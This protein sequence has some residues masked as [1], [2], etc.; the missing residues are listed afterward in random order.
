MTTT[1]MEPLLYDVKTAAR[2]LSI[3]E[4]S[5]R[6]LASAGKLPSTRI[7]DRLLFSPK[8]LAQFAGMS[9]AKTS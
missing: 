1:T 7:G 9:H 2:M 8:Q 4:C 6:S 3:S 5:V